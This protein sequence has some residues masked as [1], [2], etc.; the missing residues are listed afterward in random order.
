MTPGAFFCPNKPMQIHIFGQPVELLESTSPFPGKLTSDG[1]DFTN[2]IWSN[3]F[4]WDPKT[5]IVQFDAHILHALILKSKFR[6]SPLTYALMKLVSAVT[7]VPRWLM[8]FFWMHF[9]QSPGIGNIALAMAG[10]GVTAPIALP[11]IALH[12]A[13]QR[14]LD[15]H[16]RRQYQTV[17]DQTGSFFASLQR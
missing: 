2:Q 7:A 9:T 6:Q 4:I 5:G 3:L 11:L 10:V 8:R 12:E 17:V 16:I 13:L 1:V 14:T 15:W